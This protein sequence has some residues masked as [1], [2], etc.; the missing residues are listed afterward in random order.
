[1]SE[2]RRVSEARKEILMEKRLRKEIRDKE[3]EMVITLLERN[4][5]SA[6]MVRGGAGQGAGETS[7]EMVRGGGGQGA[8]G[9]SAEMVRGGGE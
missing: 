9:T 3:C 2:P 5:T 8:G 1:M 7:A 4:M 6:E